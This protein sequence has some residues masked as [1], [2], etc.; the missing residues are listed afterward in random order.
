M[1]DHFYI[2]ALLRLDLHARFYLAY[3][4]LL[5][6]ATTFNHFQFYSYL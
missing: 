1:G 5:L 6:I 2:S 4:S 3:P